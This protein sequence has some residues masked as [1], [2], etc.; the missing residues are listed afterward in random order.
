ME[1]CILARFRI[2]WPLLKGCCW[3]WY[4]RSNRFPTFIVSRSASSTWIGSYL[5]TQSDPSKLRACFLCQTYVPPTYILEPSVEIG[6]R[7]MDNPTIFLAKSDPSS[8]TSAY[9]QRWPRRSQ[10][11]QAGRSPGHL[12]FFRLESPHLE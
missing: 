5:P 6:T 11:E 4:D 9:S 8:P 3:R 10:Y 2:S 12:D 7:E 1:W